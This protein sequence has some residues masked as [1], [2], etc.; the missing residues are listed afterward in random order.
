MFAVLRTAV[1]LGGFDIRD[2]RRKGREERFFGL[3]AM[4]LFAE[5]FLNVGDDK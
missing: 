3:L 4:Q 1:V 5:Q 2:T